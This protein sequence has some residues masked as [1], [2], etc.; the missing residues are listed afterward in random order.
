MG[1]CTA[2]L[3]AGCVPHEETATHANEFHACT[4]DGHMVQMEL[5]GDIKLSTK[6]IVH[7]D[8]VDE[9]R[10]MARTVPYALD[11][12]Y[13]SILGQYSSAELLSDQAGDIWKK[14]TNDLR[15]ELNWVIE[16][17][18]A[19]FDLHEGDDDRDKEIDITI[20]P[21]SMGWQI[22]QNPTL[23]LCG[24]PE[25]FVGLDVDLVPEFTKPHTLFL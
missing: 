11:Y 15:G 21:K 13:A 12:T 6:G 2:F 10:S 3:L 20:T 18:S 19:A 24:T 4:S 25:Q 17:G 16:E 9:I 5:S 7:K 22:D 14:I 1:L 8:D 23:S